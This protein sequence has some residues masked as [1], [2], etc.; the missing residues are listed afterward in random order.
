M[1]GDGKSLWD[2][3]AQS[4]SQKSLYIVLLPFASCREELGASCGGEGSSNRRCAR[5][6]GPSEI[7]IWTGPQSDVCM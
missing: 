6:A 4:M 3:L 2:T 5:A 1:G 7:V